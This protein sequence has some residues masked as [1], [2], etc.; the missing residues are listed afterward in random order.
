MKDALL[1]QLGLQRWNERQN[2]SYLLMA[3]TAAR[4]L[5][6]KHIELDNGSGKENRITTY[7]DI[8]SQYLFYSF[9]NVVAS[10]LL[11]CSFVIILWTQIHLSSAAKIVGLKH[12]SDS[13]TYLVKPF[14]SSLTCLEE[15]CS[16]LNWIYS[17]SITCPTSSPAS[18]FVTLYFETYF[19]SLVFPQAPYEY[20]VAFS[21]LY[22]FLF[23]CLPFCAFLPWAIL[24]SRF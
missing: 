12:K 18:L 9:I 2:L 23:L 1:H 8:S 14:S 15:Q 10:K 20:S 21:Y 16:L 13:V 4:N 17:D 11:L 6:F 3:I 22:C 19:T 5:L 24:L 7:S